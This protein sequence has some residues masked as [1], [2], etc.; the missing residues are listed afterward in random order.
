MTKLGVGLRVLAG[1]G[2]AIGTTTPNGRL[3][4][5]FFAALAEFKRELIVERTKAAATVAGHSR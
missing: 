5:G 4:F 1:E 2:V 3:M